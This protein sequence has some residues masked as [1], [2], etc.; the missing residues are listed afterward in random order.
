MLVNDNITEAE[1]L[2]RI[3]QDEP[4]MFE[5]LFN[6]YWEDMY[7]Q[8]YLRL[9]DRS[10]AEDMVQDIFANIWTRRHS[11]VVTSSLSAYLRTALKYQIIK[12][13]IK[14]DVKQKAADYLLQ[15]MT[16]IETTVL[17]ML[18]V[19]DIQVTLD[20]AVQ[21]LPGN[22]GKIF[23]LRMEG[24]TIAE[25][26]EAIGLSE[27]TVKNNTSDALRRLRT[28]LMKEHPEIPSSFYTILFLFTQT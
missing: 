5:L 27:Q 24:F 14:A 8:A 28:V 21:Q 12:R 4:G 13:T 18:A 19:N 9:G 11:L 7:R 22:M 26:A 16:D 2:D 1:L 6:R 3:R 25:I 23:G 17:D 15:K 20:K 10:E